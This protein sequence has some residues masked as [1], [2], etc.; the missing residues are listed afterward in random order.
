MLGYA[1]TAQGLAKLQEE[2]HHIRITT[3]DMQHNLNA[4][5]LL[6]SATSTRQRGLA[7]ASQPRR[8]RRAL[9]GQQGSIVLCNDRHPSMQPVQTLH[10]QSCLHLTT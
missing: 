7:L 6:S 3:I 5:L 4:G 10:W 1:A 2:K 9:S 8:A